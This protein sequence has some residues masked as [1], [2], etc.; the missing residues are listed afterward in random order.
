MMLFP[1][2]MGSEMFYHLDKLQVVSELHKLR[3]VLAAVDFPRLSKT[4]SSAHLFRVHGFNKG[5]Q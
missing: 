2:S 1:L 4:V 5:S 3:G